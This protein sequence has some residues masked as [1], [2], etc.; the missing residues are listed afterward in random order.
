MEKKILRFAAIFPLLI[1]FQPS[2]DTEELYSPVSPSKKTLRKRHFW[3]P[4]IWDFLFPPRC[5]VRHQNNLQVMVNRLANFS[6]PGRFDSFDTDLCVYICVCV[7]AC[8]CILKAL[9][10][11]RYRKNTVKGPRQFRQVA[12]YN[13]KEREFCTLTRNDRWFQCS[14]PK[15][16]VSTLAENTEISPP[17]GRSTDDT[18]PST[19]KPKRPP[20][21]ATVLSFFKT[22]NLNN[23]GWVCW[24]E[25][26]FFTMTWP[27]F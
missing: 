17:P 12:H 16:T 21:S 24:N 18:L 5:F 4:A 10:V 22:K 19:A 14:E 3:F 2:G 7:R 9:P 27:H 6:K 8:V 20:D 13:A 1:R 25:S 11:S 23:L 15:Q 26:Y